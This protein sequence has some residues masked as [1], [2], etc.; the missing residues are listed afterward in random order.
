[1]I[2]P[3]TLCFI[4]SFLI[5]LFGLITSPVTNLCAAEKPAFNLK[6]TKLAAIPED[7]QIGQI[8]F[9]PDGGQVAYLAMKG[10]ERFVVIGE[11]RGNAYEW[12]RVPFFSPD[13]KKVAYLAGR[14]GKSFIG[15]NGKEF[16]AFGIACRPVFSPD[17][18]KIAY[19][20]K[21]GDKKIGVNREFVVVG[22]KKGKPYDEVR[23][24]G[25][26]PDGGRF[27]YAAR[28]GDTWFVVVN[29]KEGSAYETVEGLTFG[30]T[31][32]RQLIY[33]A[34]RE[35]KEFIVIEGEEK[36]ADEVEAQLSDIE[37]SPVAYRVEKNGKWSV[38]IGH[39][40]SKAYDYVGTIILSKDGKFVGYGARIG[41]ELWWKVEKVE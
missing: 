27:V 5:L 32:G 31:D 35:G 28:K 26:S 21:G 12:V 3:V 14:E 23:R 38:F 25:F 13:G 30:G 11:K 33:Q 29:E 9:S 6:E 16:E 20:V 34:K 4:F 41:Q 1:M 24:L 8:V 22:N 19:E 18:S 7:Y 17:G 37:D 2:N 36:P 15:V 40:E 39:R 10:T